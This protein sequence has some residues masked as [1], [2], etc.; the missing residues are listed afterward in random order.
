MLT[1]KR[2]LTTPTDR[3]GKAARFFVFQ[4]KLWS[5]CARLLKK[6]RS[7]QQAAALSYYTIFG[8]VPLA[9][10]TLL[11]FQL[12]PAYSEIGDKVKDFVY[13]EIHLS[14]IKYADAAQTEGAIAVTEYIDQISDKFFESVSEGKGSVTLVSVIIVIWAALS[15]LS[16]VEK[17]FNNIWHI[18]KGRAFLHRVIN[19]WALVT[20]GP[21]LIGMGI[22]ITTRYAAIDEIQ[23]T[24]FT[25]IGPAALSYLVATVAFFLLYFILPN[26]K[27]SARSAIW[28][29]AMAALVWSLAKWIFGVYVTR[30]IPYSQLYGVL[31]LVP[32]AV[33]WIYITWLIVLFGL[34]LTFTTQHL[35][36]LDAAEI[37]ASRETED[38]FIAN[39][40]TFINVVREI[41]V[42]FETNKAPVASEAVLSKLNIPA[43]LGE[44]IFNSLI[45]G[46]LIAK[47]CEPKEGY[48]PAK[49]P[50]NIKLSDIAEIASRAGFA[51]RLVDSPAILDELNKSQRDALAKCNL[52]QIIDTD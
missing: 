33:L 13:Q 38:Y 39:D 31:G 36:S 12:F 18:P 1:F 42:S 45:S 22:Y 46:G 26:T 3:L 4:T 35:E 11:I 47:A 30:F 52:K 49:D 17:A 9:I 14:N 19:Y 37:A 20:L 40:L 16:T 32:L 6:N 50:D 28:G 5:H 25:H 10:V 51:Q 8:I 44:K 29:A 41:A 27:V 7:G 15:L 34:Q 24:I 43:E 2:I 48:L 21:L 23:K